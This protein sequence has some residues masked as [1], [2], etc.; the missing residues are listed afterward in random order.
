MV[1]WT[2]DQSVDV[3]VATTADCLALNL[4][5]MMGDLMA[6]LKVALSVALTAARK[7]G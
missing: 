2:A 6:G 7:D 4:V 3:M 5:D 1:V